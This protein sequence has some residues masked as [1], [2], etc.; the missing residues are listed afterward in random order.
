MSIVLYTIL[1]L[2]EPESTDTILATELVFSPTIVS[3][4]IAFWKIGSV[5]VNTNLSNIGRFVSKDS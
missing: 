2:L 5:D 3:P 4:T 1:I